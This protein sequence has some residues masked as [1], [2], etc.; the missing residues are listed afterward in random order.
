[1]ATRWTAVARA[2]D[3]G[4]RAIGHIIER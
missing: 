4:D 3:R 2:R 1:V